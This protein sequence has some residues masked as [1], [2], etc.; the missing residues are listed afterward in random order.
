MD[1]RFFEGKKIF[2]ADLPHF[3]GSVIIRDCECLSW[4]D[5][6]YT[7]SALNPFCSTLT[8][9]TLTFINSANFS[10]EM[11]SQ[12]KAPSQRAARLSALYNT[13][14]NFVWTLL[15]IAP[16]AYYFYLQVPLYWLFAIVPLCILPYF[17]KPSVID[18]LDLSKSRDLYLRLGVGVIQEY[19]QHGGAINRIIR[20]TYP[21]YRMV[22][23]KVTMQRQMS[24]TYM[25]ERFHLGMLLAFLAVTV[26]AFVHRFYIWGLVMLGCNILY[27]VYPV[28]L[29]QYVRLRLRRLLVK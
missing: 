26:H 9:H 18:A 2:T 19:V 15:N 20:R 27:N 29:Q 7:V 8:L 17:L 28:L 16:V 21:A 1:E 3:A 5:D 23:D 13:V 11:S 6:L 24:A 14:P 10:T 12:E 4:T 25:F 22:Y